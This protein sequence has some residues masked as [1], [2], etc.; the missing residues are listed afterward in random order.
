TQVTNTGSTIAEG[1]TDTL[2]NTELAF[3]DSE[4]A[5]TAITFTVTTS[6]TNGQLELT[7]NPTVAITSFTQDDLD[8]NHVRFVHNGATGDN[9]EFRFDVD[10]GAGNGVTGLRFAISVTPAPTLTLLDSVV[11]LRNTPVEQVA[12][13]SLSTEP[14]DPAPVDVDTDGEKTTHSAPPN[15]ASPVTQGEE[16]LTPTIGLTEAVTLL[17]ANAP[18]PALERGSDTAPG[19]L[20]TET[21]ETPHA[22]AQHQVD[23]DETPV[24]E[25]TQSVINPQLRRAMDNMG[26]QMDAEHQT[27]V[28]ADKVADSAVK[29]AGSALSVGS[30]SWLLR[31]GTLFA[32]VLSSLPAWKGF[33]PLPVLRS[34]KED[35]KRAKEERAAEQHKEDQD[36]VGVGEILDGA[37][38]GSHAPKS[39]GN[40][41][42]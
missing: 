17:L 21:I 32:S 8:N 38:I 6:P 15:T 39:H 31:G 36:D 30:V 9:I 26:A 33:D 18:N 29:V 25:E 13:P 27:G 19:R 40:H 7:T 2:S 5:A 20:E 16:T 22:P 10:D 28:R 37:A 24:P 14:D 34:S 41:E 4:Q 35:K 12:A 1:G 11:A 3:T 23:A 42:Q